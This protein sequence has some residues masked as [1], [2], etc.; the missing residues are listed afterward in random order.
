MWIVSTEGRGD[1]S[2]NFVDNFRPGVSVFSNRQLMIRAIRKHLAEYKVNKDVEHIIRVGGC[3]IDG[4]NAIRVWE[5][6]L[7]PEELDDGGYYWNLP[8]GSDAI[9]NV[10]AKRGKKPAEKAKPV[11]TVKPPP[12]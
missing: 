9:P 4:E 5:T 11:E 3:D 10:P 7:N 2:D 8:R 6:E 12:Q 1:G